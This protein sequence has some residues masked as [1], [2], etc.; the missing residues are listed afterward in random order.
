MITGLDHAQLAMP[1]GLE[2]EARRFYCGLLGLLELKKPPT[3]AARGGVWCRLPDGRELHLGVEDPFTPA[4]KAHVALVVDA[5]D[6]LAGRIAEAG[7]PVRW[8]DELA[9]RRRFYSEDPFGN[10]LE[11]MEPVRQTPDTE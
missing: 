11:L 6:I 8:D 4:R 5:L 9:P 7:C 2:H 3:L 10:R 1:P